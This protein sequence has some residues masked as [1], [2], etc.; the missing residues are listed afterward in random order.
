[1]KTLIAIFSFFSLA[2]AATTPAAAASTVHIHKGAVAL[3]VPSENMA[4]AKVTATCSGGTGTVTVMITQTAA[5]SNAGTA[6]SGTGSSSVKC[7]GLLRT[8]AVSVGSAFDNLGVATA[9][10]MLTAI[11]GPATETR[12]IVIGFPV[13]ENMEQEEGGND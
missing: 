1:M 9:T 7:D 3:F 10:V 4:I 5:Q 11:S 12:T 8:I 6:A 2:L 13:I